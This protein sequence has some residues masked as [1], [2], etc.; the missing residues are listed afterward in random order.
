MHDYICICPSVLIILNKKNSL[1]SLFICSFI[2]PP[3]R[4]SVRPSICL[5][6]C[7][8]KTP[9]WRNPQVKNF[10]HKDN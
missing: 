10:L 7:R 9:K 1:F 2:H 4:P 5:H 3:V 8:L 6:V